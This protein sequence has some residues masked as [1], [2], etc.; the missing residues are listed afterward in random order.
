[1]LAQID[2]HRPI[3]K[4][5]AKV[6]ALFYMAVKAFETGDFDGYA[7]YLKAACDLYHSVPTVTVEFE[8]HLAEICYSR[9][10]G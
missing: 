8:Y 2:T 7:K 3:L 4:E 6:Q 9:I 1:M 5:R 10:D